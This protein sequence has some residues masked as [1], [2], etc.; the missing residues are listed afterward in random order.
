MMN[1]NNNN[2]CL[3]FPLLIVVAMFLASNHHPVAFGFQSTLPTV[4]TPLSS[5]STAVYGLFDGIVKSM[6]S[7]YAGG[8]DS[9]YAKIK[10]KDEQKELAQKKRSTERKKKGYTELKDVKKKSFAKMTYGKKAAA[11]EE[12]EEEEP[13]KKKLFGMF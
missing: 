1:N 4:T 11:E 10:A 5:S 13:K 9:P 6:E 12:E 7:G 2:N 8:E 3:L